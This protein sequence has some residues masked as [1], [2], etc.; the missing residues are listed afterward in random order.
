MIC[1]RS[2][3]ERARSVRKSWS[4]ER[5]GVGHYPTDVIA[6]DCDFYTFSGHK[7]FGPTGIGVLWGRRELLTAMPP[8]QGGAT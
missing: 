5:S 4:T 1:L 6:L 8:Y 3:V 7:L 2:F